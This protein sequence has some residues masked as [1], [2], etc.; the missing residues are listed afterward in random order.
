MVVFIISAIVARTVDLLLTVLCNAQESGV[1]GT[2]MI[3]L[4]IFCR[5]STGWQKDRG[6]TSRFRL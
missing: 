6:L 3:R 5:S 4:L 1:P 2:K